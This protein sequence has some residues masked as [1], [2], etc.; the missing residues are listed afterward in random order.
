MAQIFISYSRKNIDF[1]RRLAGALEQRG[2]DFWVDWEGIPPTVDW[3]KEIQRGI[4]EADTFL[5]IVSPDSIISKVCKN[6]L[7]LAVQNGKRLIP[8]VAHEVKWDDVPSTLS[9][10]NYTFFRK[11][12]DFDP[13]L[14][15]LLTAINTDYGWVQ[16]HRR[17]QVKALEWERGNRDG[18]FL[19]RGRDLEDAESQILINAAKNPHPT[20]IQRD[21]VLKSRQGSTKQR[22]ITTGILIGLIAGM[23]GV[24]T[25]LVRPYVEDAIARAQAQELSRMITVPAGS[26]TAHAQVG[27]KNQVVDL[28]EF[29]IEMQ[30]VTNR[31]YS[32]C[33]KVSKCTPPIGSA[34]FNDPQKQ[35]DPVVWLTIF[36][37]ATYCEWVGRRLPS[38]AEWERAARLFAQSILNE[39]RFSFSD[40]Y[41]W[42]SSYLE[43]NSQSRSREWDGQSKSLELAWDFQLRGG[44]LSSTGEIGI[45]PNNSGALGTTDNFGFRCAN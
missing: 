3:M 22:R 23:L 34:D 19:L 37:T 8:V 33:V 43:N 44:S 10:L 40:H 18:G 5:F 15:K 24:I 35:E 9:H 17:L 2:L 27:D 12:D 14:E 25:L 32:L 21:Y 31:V 41:E 36:Q 13:A 26:I 4:E 7:D 42:T 30:A 38:T 29:R 6:E 20:E 11:S 39:H 28:P 45:Y 1:A 16:T